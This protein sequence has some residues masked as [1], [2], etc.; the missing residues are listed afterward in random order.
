MTILKEPLYDSPS[1]K[2]ARISTTAKLIEAYRP[3]F[4]LHKQFDN[5]STVQL[6]EIFRTTLTTYDVLNREFKTHSQ[7][8]ANLQN[9]EGLTTILR[10]I[11]K[12]REEALLT[13]KK[14]KCDV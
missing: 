10:A 2:K 1:A 14:R 9:Q 3:C 12:I 13:L 7:T 11:K 4:E 8:T 5:F 6:D